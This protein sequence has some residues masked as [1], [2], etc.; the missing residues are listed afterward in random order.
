MV[1]IDDCAYEKPLLEKEVKLCQLLPKLIR[2]E[3][4][5]HL[6]F[7][8]HFEL[9]QKRFMKELFSSDSGGRKSHSVHKVRPPFQKKYLK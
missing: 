5:S 3:T 6:L 9:I 7:D 4:A 8:T 2:K 1:K